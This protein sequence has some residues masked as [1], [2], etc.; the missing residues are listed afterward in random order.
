MPHGKAIWN[1]NGGFVSVL[2]THLFIYIPVYIISVMTQ[3]Y[4]YV[5][6]VKCKWTES[7]TFTVEVLSMKNI[8]TKQ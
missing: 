2:L 4:H 8:I 6:M 3:L 1:A 5:N 7:L